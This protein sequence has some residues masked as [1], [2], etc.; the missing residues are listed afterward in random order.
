MAASDV[1]SR[2]GRLR[3]AL[4]CE[5]CGE[6]NYKT[7]IARREGSQPLCLKKFCKTCERHTVHKESK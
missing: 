2:P 1:T 3:V 7:T 4:A 6:R 5:V